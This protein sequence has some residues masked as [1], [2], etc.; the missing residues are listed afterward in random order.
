MP[1]FGQNLLLI[2]WWKQVRLI[3]IRVIHRRDLWRKYFICI[4]KI[5][6]IIV[7]CIFGIILTNTRMLLGYMS[8]LSYPYGNH[9]SII[10]IDILKVKQS[11]FR[12]THKMLK[13][14]TDKFTNKFQ[15]RLSKINSNLKRRMVFYEVRWLWNFRERY[16]NYG[17][18]L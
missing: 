1:T 4:W 14:N 18:I 8:I 3:L 2:F 5:M 17:S 13:N 6:A 10:E 12:N 16:G 11:L 7:D 15:L 9:L